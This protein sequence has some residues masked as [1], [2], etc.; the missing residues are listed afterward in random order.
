[1]TSGFFTYSFDI[2]P[3]NFNTYGAWDDRGTRR[4]WFNPIECGTVTGLMM[5]FAKKGSPDYQ[6]AVRIWQI[7]SNFTLDV[8]SGTDSHALLSEGNI[9]A[10]SVTVNSGAW[11][12]LFV[13]M[14]PFYLGADNWYNTN[15]QSSNDAGVYHPGAWAGGLMIDFEVKSGTGTDFIMLPFKSDKM[16]GHWS[17]QADGGNNRNLATEVHDVLPFVVVGQVEPSSQWMDRPGIH[18]EVQDG[19]RTDDSRG[20]TTANRGRAAPFTAKG[21]EI[22]RI[23]ALTEHDSN[24]SGVPAKYHAQIWTITTSFLPDT[25]VGCADL[26]FDTNS[27]WL[28]GDLNDMGLP[29]FWVFSGGLAITSGNDYI[30]VVE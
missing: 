12:W 2:S 26:S 7:N 27:N 30:F 16:V 14:T 8:N 6:S 24:L 21:S 23:A 11:S 20:W 5:P 28:P 4:Q 15:A 3:G 10:S 18:Y 1:M 25:I 13:P 17:N 9:D 22:T 19:I 29:L